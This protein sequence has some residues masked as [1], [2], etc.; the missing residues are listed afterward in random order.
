[1]HNKLL[2]KKTEV[3]ILSSGMPACA[4]RMPSLLRENAV[5]ET[6]N[7]DTGAWLSASPYSSQCLRALGCDESSLLK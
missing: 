5:A 7:P 3:L 6:T 4:R 2:C 1:M